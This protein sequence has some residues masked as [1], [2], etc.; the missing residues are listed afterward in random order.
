MADRKF[1]IETLALHAGQIP[2]AATGAEDRTRRLRRALRL[3]PPIGAIFWSFLALTGWVPAAALAYVSWTKREIHWDWAQLTQWATGNGHAV[4]EVVTEVGSGLDGKRPKLRR[5]L[6][7]PSAGV[8]VVEHRDRL[9]WCG[10]GAGS[11]R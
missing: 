9:A 6:S 1:G 3:A 11:T 10:T 5:I 7:D 8:V 2:D 4:G